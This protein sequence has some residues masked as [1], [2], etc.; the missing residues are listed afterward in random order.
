MRSFSFM[1]HSAGPVSPSKMSLAAHVSSRKSVIHVVSTITGVLVLVGSLFFKLPQV[2]RIARSRS[3]EG[4]SVAMYVLETI[5]VTFSA[6]YFAR[7]AF[8][9]STYGELV[10]VMAQNIVILM[11]ISIYEKM[12]RTHVV[13]SAVLYF[14]V[15]ALLMSPIL[16]IKVLVTLQIIAIPLLNLS[17][18]PQILLN[19]K[20]KGTGE[21]A[22]VTLILQVIGNIARIFTTVASVKDALMLTA[23]SVSTFFN[24]IILLQWL[25][26]NRMQIQSEQIAPRP[27]S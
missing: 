17:R 24:T 20:R 8:A 22:P 26:Y 1:A 11:L 23:V 2:F 27:K 14:C 12:S 25:Y 6:S 19:W 16:P 7:R 15:L 3:G 10:F 21:L 13:G 5:A 9:F 4:V 18:I